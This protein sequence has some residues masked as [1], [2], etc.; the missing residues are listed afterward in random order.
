MTLPQGLK[1]NELVGQG[2]K[3]EGPKTRSFGLPTLLRKPDGHLV[4]VGA[5]GLVVE[6]PFTIGSEENSGG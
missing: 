3:I 4:Q 1:V 2:Y 5:D 6:D